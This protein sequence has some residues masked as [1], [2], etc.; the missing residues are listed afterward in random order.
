MTRRPAAKSKQKPGRP[1]LPSEAQILEFIAAS[2]GKV[3]KRE[4]AR[5]FGVR[6]PDRMEFNRL[7]VWSTRLEGGVFLLGLAALLL[8]AR[9]LQ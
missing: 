1:A 5:A 9:R 6:G 3:G 7:H 8:T 4:I 2:P